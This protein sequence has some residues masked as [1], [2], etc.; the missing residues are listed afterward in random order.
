MKKLFTIVA[1]ALC[2]LTVSAKE[3]IPGFTPGT[4]TFGGW[5]WNTISTLGQGEVINNGNG[6]ADDSGVTYFDASDHDYVVFKYSTATCAKMKAIVQYNCKGTAGQWGPEFNEGSQEFVLNVNGGIMAIKLNADYSDKVFSIAMQDPGSAGT[7]DVTDVY[8]ATEEEYLAAKA[9]ADK[10][11]KVMVL[12][13]EGGTHTLAAGD[14]GWDSKWLDATDISAF[15]TAVI[16]VESV[17]GHGKI[18]FEAFEIDLPA[19]ETAY[20]ATADISSVASIKQYAYQNLYKIDEASEVPDGETVIKVKKVYLTSKTKQE[21]DEEISTGISN[22]IAAP[23]A[24]NNVRY[25]F[26]GQRVGNGAKMY[27]MNGKKYMK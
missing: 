2:A 5:S 11:E 26:A 13:G 4:L 19:S 15:N 7:V 17:I 14:W 25:N 27:I 24:Q 23:K 3:T 18:N 12:D 9:E 8:F 1:A 16:E 21:V 22:M 10:I 6:T 20:T